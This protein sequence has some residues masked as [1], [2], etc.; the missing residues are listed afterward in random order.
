MAGSVPWAAAHFL[1]YRY[2]SARDG[3]R[4]VVPVGGGCLPA[5]LVRG[6]REPKLVDC[7]TFL[8]AVAVYAHAGVVEWDARAYS[9]LQ[10]MGSDLW[11]PVDCWVRHGLGD[12][13][14]GPVQGWGFYQ[15]W[16]N[17]SGHQWAYHGGMG[18]RLHSS[19]TG[20]AGP[21]WERVEWKGLADRYVDGIRGVELQSVAR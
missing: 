19:S 8:A 18:I 17:G 13:V 21:T 12:E 10:I 6:P 4:N 14:D 5:N 2:A 11:S 16:G 20:K 15:G 1:G 3:D 9:D 7:S